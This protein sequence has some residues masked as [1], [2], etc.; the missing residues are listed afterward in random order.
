MRAILTAEWPCLPGVCQSRG[1]R[2]GGQ[3]QEGGLCCLACSPV[4]PELKGQT[5]SRAS[6]VG[7]EVGVVSAR[8]GLLSS[9][10]PVRPLQS[11]CRR[12]ISGGS[13]R[14][15]LWGARQ[16]SLRPPSSLFPPLFTCS[17]S[18]A[19]LHVL[20]STW[21]LL[22]CETPFPRRGGEGLV[23]RPEPE[24]HLTP[25]PHCCVHA[26]CRCQR[27]SR[28]VAHGKVWEQRNL[29][30]DARHSCFTVS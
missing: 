10:R 16:P 20:C 21:S 8:P 23:G 4:T 18:R 14:E 9:P 11:W 1:S 28:T 29:Q 5:H 30:V 17:A 15:G 12:A 6:A 3:T 25:V 27:R 2:C 7:A 24:P 22:P 26:L 13:G 19:L